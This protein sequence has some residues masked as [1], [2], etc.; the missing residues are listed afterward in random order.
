MSDLLGLALTMVLLIG[1][2]LF[3]IR[4]ARG[5]GG[6][7]RSLRGLRDYSLSGAW[8]HAILAALALGQIAARIGGAV[9]G[10]VLLACLVGGM[11]GWF[12]ESNRLVSLG[13]GTIGGVAAVIG[14]LAFASDAADPSDLAVRGAMM[15]A[16]GLLFG[17]TALLRLQPLAGLTWFA[18]LSIVVFLASPG[19]ASVAQVGGFSGALLALVGTG[20]V[21]GLALAP[22]IG[23]RLGAVAVSVTKVLGPTLG[24][25]RATASDPFPV[26]LATL[27]TYV[28]VRF[29]A[30]RF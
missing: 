6:A 5:V 26:I 25:F 13:L 24:Y 1:V 7:A 29:V 22:Q 20:A 8:A 21:I 18:A 4:G 10:F 28:M 15:F 16:L 30:A 23:I 14:S 17:L 3:M 11:C 2:L 9:E 19:G 27:A 12:R